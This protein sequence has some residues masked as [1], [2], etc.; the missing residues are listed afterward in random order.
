M[1]VLIRIQDAFTSLTLRS[2]VNFD[3]ICVWLRAYELFRSG[4]GSFE[5]RVVS[6][7][8]DSLEWVA[9]DGFRSCL[10][11][12]DG[13]GWFWAVCCFSSY[14]L[15]NRLMKNSWEAFLDRCCHCLDFMDLVHGYSNSNLLVKDQV[16]LKSKIR[17]GYIWPL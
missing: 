11:V 9:A 3:S 16:S 13:L 14:G 5:L 4:F 2:W 6:R 12:S 10:V 1:I 15:R 7:A 17:S 8:E